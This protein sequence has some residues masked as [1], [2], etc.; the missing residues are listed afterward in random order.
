VS[1]GVVEFVVDVMGAD[2]T[3]CSRYT[4]ARGEAPEHPDPVLAFVASPAST[5][6]GGTNDIQRNIIGD[7]VLRLPREPGIDPNTPWSEIPRS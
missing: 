6:A 7:R 2:G 4:D 3:L 5:I 1:Q